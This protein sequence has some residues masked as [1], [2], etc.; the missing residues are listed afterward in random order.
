MLR[1]WAVPVIAAA[2]AAVTL[3]AASAFAVGSWSVV[4]AP[5]T[6]ANAP[7]TGVATVS[8]TNAWAVG[9]RNGNAFT[10]VG[11]KILIDHWDGTA[12]SQVATPATP[13][14]TALL[15]AVSASSASDVWA[16]GRT[17]VN[18]SNFNGLALHWDG[19]A[20]SVSSSFPAA[21]A[22]TV[23]T[24]VTD[25]G[26][27]DAY[28]TGN[29]S[30][31]PRGHLAH[32]D[33]T[34][35]S[36]V[37]VPLPPNAPT[38][39]TL[40]AISASGPS[41]VWAVGTFLNS[42]TEQFDNFA[43][44]FDG[45]KWAVAATPV[46]AGSLHALQANSPSDVWAAG[47]STSNG[48]LIEHFNG[49][50]WSVVPSPSPGARAALGG[51]TTSNAANNVWAVGSFTPAGSINPQT[52]TLNWNGTAWTQ[53]PSPDPATSDGV[54]AVSTLPGNAI[55]WAVGETGQSGAFNPLVLRNG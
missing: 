51:L 20:W 10:N 4:P 32:W 37:T 34:A 35:W 41:N 19:T 38:N 6:G 21:I 49:T 31:I 17:Q 40:D 11:A 39:T 18:K 30:T 33:G 14:N 16:I 36:A 13:G 42:V 15:N 3:A 1:S 2:G 24:G 25:I 7:L 43:I 26:P 55:V 48:T 27:A 8:D 44:H 53:V 46:N 54:G 50:A 22:T 5:P 12:W 47:S 45:S 28:A 23:T 9:F 29:N 52:L